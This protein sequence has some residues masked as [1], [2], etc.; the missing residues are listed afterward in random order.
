MIHY[1]P[2][3]LFF[4]INRFINFYNPHAILVFETELWPNMISMAHKKSIPLYLMNGRLSEK[5]YQRYK[6][7]SWFFSEVLQRITFLFVQ[8][9][10]HKELS[11]IHI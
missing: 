8:T 2:W 9:N 7:W 11:L 6:L 5:S 3:D 4:I 1:A 10:A